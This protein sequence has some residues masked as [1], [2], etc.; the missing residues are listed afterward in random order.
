VSELKPYLA[1]FTKEDILEITEGRTQV[2]LR[3][4]LDTF[5][6]KKYVT[7]GNKTSAP[8]DY[9]FEHVQI[10]TYSWDIGIINSTV[11]SLFDGL[12]P[13]Q[14]A[15]DK[16]LAKKTQLLSNYKGPVPI[17]NMDC[18]V[19]VK[20]LSNST[21]EALF[22]DTSL[23]PADVVTVI[24]PTPLDPQL[25]AEVEALKAQMHELAGIQQVSMDIENYRS[26]AAVI[27]LD[28]QRD[29]SF[30]SQVSSLAEFT[31]DVLVM[32]VDYCAA[33]K[34][35]MPYSER[36]GIDWGDIKL[37]FDESYLDVKPIHELKQDGGTMDTPTEPDYAM[38][39]VDKFLIAVIKDGV[40]LEKMD[41][42]LDYVMVKQ[43]AAVKLVRMKSIT[44]LGESAFMMT[45]LT[46]FLVQC[47]VEDLK[48][49]EASISG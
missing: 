44:D 25:G 40:G 19:I 41:F 29:T 5:R 24:E 46:N 14:R 28:Q 12:Y 32:Y 2:D 13:I 18:D 49:G 30:Q 26:A 20:Q 8:T 38:I 27:A 23:K 42:S 10:K 36:T 39:N 11:A 45:N 6:R 31:R 35:P 9:P 34:V 15:L 1:G 4:Y 21:G 43:I 16:L 3:L 7:V 47:F 22:L 48:R 37:L 17:F 33:T